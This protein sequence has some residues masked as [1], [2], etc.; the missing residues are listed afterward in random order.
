VRDEARS[1]QRLGLPGRLACVSVPLAHSSF[2]GIALHGVLLVA[3]GTQLS[4][5]FSY[6]DGHAALGFLV[7]M[8]GVRKAAPDSPGL[9]LMGVG[10]IRPARVCTPCGSRK[11]PVVLV[12][13]SLLVL[14]LP[15][16][17][18]RVPGAVARRT[19]PPLQCLHLTCFAPHPPPHP[20]PF[21]IWG[22]AQVIAC[23][24]PGLAHVA[25][26]RVVF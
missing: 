18:F 11:D 12:P 10:F 26:V 13:R 16:C 14:L 17:G 21:L 23:H 2:L 20:A 9:D 7:G 6:L 25:L 4:S 8:V 5:Y 22:V 3:S 24:T 1:R 15:G 19:P